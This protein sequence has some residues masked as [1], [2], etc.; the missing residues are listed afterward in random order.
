[1]FNFVDLYEPSLKHKSP[2]HGQLTLG[3]L[4]SNSILL[5]FFLRKHDVL[6]LDDCD[7]AQFVQDYSFL[8]QK[9][10]YSDS[11]EIKL[12]FNRCVAIIQKTVVNQKPFIRLIGDELADRGEND[13]FILL[14]LKQLHQ[15]QV[16]YHILLSN[17]G[18]SF[19]SLYLGW[20]NKN[21]QKHW[22]LQDIFIPSF[23]ALK[24]TIDLQFFDFE[25][26]NE[27]VKTCYL[28]YLKLLDYSLSLTSNLI[29]IYSHAAIGVNVLK[30]LGTEMDVLFNTHT[31]FDIA[32]FIE[33][34]NLKFQQ[35]TFTDLS[36]TL[37]QLSGTSIESEALE[38]LSPLA[39]SAI[40]QICWNRDYAKQLRPTWMN[41]Y[42][43]RYI[44]GHDHS[45]DYDKSQHY[46]SLDGLLGKTS[47]DYQGE[48]KTLSSQDVFL[49]NHHKKTHNIGF[50]GAINI[51]KHPKI[52]PLLPYLGLIM[53]YMLYKQHQ[54][55]PQAITKLLVM[56]YQLIQAYF[57]FLKKLNQQPLLMDKPCLKL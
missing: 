41:G 8:Q 7:Y 33:E 5:L 26:L 17:H 20:S 53:I 54:K 37:T 46:V 43:L 38:I 47:E 18:L 4:H 27:I 28:P 1:M 13:L 55:N 22:L 42:H 49:L 9:E 40:W 51:L 15:H 19:L 44:H 24:K 25:T 6:V 45:Q 2:F 30:D 16:P 10:E 34:I 14:I 32:R 56:S 29:T 52:K 21:E 23:R 36:C 3:D 50:F 11:E 39:E 35:K 48:L 12:V 31:H 57:P